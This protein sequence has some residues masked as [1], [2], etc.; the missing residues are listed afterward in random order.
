MSV[1][2]GVP[3][4]AQ[5]GEA[6][7]AEAPAG[8]A[9]A[10]SALEDAMEVVVTLGVAEPLARGG[11]ARGATAQ[12]KATGCTRAQAL[13]ELEAEVPRT[14][15]GTAPE[16]EATLEGVRTLS[17]AGAPA[18]GST[19]NYRGEATPAAGSTSAEASTK[20]AAPAPP[21]MTR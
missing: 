11:G 19:C 6:A 1:E 10:T 20:L 2:T 14:T 12:V 15:A 5:L 4:G 13:M 8:I 9:V 16:V 3:P 17:T 21:K 18:R 7:R